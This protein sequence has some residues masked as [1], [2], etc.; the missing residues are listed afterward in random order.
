MSWC[1]RALSMNRDSVHA[2]LYVCSYHLYLRSECCMQLPLQKRDFLMMF[3]ELSKSSD[4]QRAISDEEVVSYC[5]T[6]LL[7]GYENLAS[8][9]TFTSYLLA[10]NL[11]VQERLCAEIDLFFKSSPVIVASI[12]P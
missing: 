3:V 2:I 4:G 11:R 6:I 7:A 9:L 10:L 1:H 8:T 5:V 12:M